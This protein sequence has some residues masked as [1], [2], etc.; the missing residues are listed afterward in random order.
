MSERN[1]KN[2]L[3]KK[4]HN[5]IETIHNFHLNMFLNPARG[6]C[7]FF[8]RQ[9][10]NFFSEQYLINNIDTNSIPKL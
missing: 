9:P 8:E 4:R 10:Y 1:Y 3:R 5:L 7:A 6:G 2:I